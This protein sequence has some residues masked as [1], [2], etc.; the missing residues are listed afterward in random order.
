MTVEGEDRNRQIE[1]HGKDHA[2][3]YLEEYPEVFAEIANVLVFDKEIVNQNE[4]VQG[5]TESIYKAEDGKRFQEQR[6]DTTKYIQNLGTIVS[7]IGFENQSEEEKDMV[8]RVMGYDYASYRSQIKKG[9]ERYPVVTAV[10]YFGDRKWTK[11]R[12]LKKLFGENMTI[13]KDYVSDYKIRVIDVP[14]IPKKKREQLT[15]CGS[16]S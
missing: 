4:L 15:T 10:L 6:R 2:G 12:S 7:L 8:I 13:Y 14:R 11:A 3:K 9:V 5:P 16:G 1:N